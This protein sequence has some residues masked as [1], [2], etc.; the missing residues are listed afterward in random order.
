MRIVLRIAAAL[1]ALALVASTSVTTAQQP[2]PS[3]LTAALLDSLRWRNIGP[4]GNRFSAVASIAGNTRIYYAGAAS[5][6]IY[7]TT[8]GGVHWSAIFDA[9]PVQSIGSLAIAESDPNIVWAGTGEGKIRSHISVGQGVYKSTDAGATWR[10]MGLEKTGRIPRTIIHPTNPDIVFVCALGHSYGDQPERGVYRTLDGGAT[11]TQVLF[12][13]QKTG[14]SDLAIDPSN[15]RTLFAGMWQFEIHTWGRRSGGPGSGLFVS[16]D[17]GA[18]WTRQIG[19]GLPASPVGKVAVAIARSNPQRVFA[20]IETGDGIPWEGQPTGTGQLWRSED[21]GRRWALINRDRNVM[22]RAHYYSRL[23]VSPGDED[24]AYFL[25]ASFAKSIDG[26]STLVPQSGG[27]APGGDHHDIWIDPN[28]PDRMIVAHDQGLSI[29][30]N[31]GR[32]WFRQRLTNAQIY[33]VTVDNA[34]PYNVLGNKQD[35]PSYR[36]PSNSRVPGGRSAGISRGMWHSVGGGESGWATPDPTDPTIVWST[37]SGSGNVGGIVVRFEENRRQFRNVEVWPHQ[38]NGPAEGVRYR[39]VWDAPLHISPHDH[40]TIYT[41]SQHVHRTQDGGQSWQVISPDLTRND[42]S[43]MGSSGGLTG[44]NIGVEYSGVVFGIAESPVEKGMIWVGTN[45]GQVQVTRD[46]GTTWTNLTKNLPLLPVWGSVRSIAPSRWDAATAWLTVDAHQENN[47]D[48]WVYQTTDYGKT[49]RLIV[50]GL[51][52]N[53]LSYAKVIHE[54]PVR[55][56]LLYLGTENAI[57][58]SFNAGE[59]WLPL[60]MNLP[61]APVSGIVVQ[62]HFNDL[63]ISTYGRGFWILDDITPLQQL[64]DSVL[65]KGAHLFAPRAAYR[66][67]PITPPSTTYDDPT[68]GTDPEYGAAI[69]YYL[70][71]PAKAPPTVAILDGAGQVIRTLTGPNAAGLNRV[72]WDLRGALSAEVRLFTSPMYAPHIVPGADGR[73]APGTGRISI[74]HPPGT[75]TVRLTVDSVTQTQQLLV[76]K[77]PNSAGTEAD[78]AAQIQ[79]V[80]GLR[81]E[82]NSAASAVSRIESARVQLEALQRLTAD[83]AVRRAAADMSRKLIDLEMNLVELR[84]TGAGQDGV[85]FGSK[86]ISK[87][88]YLANGMSNGDFKPTNQH[89]E[90]QQILSTELRTHLT[91]LNALMTGDL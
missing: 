48:P 7:K 5:G 11:W 79:V 4:E 45:D 26:G 91:A 49:W 47:R 61:H 51:P 69:N 59:S 17:G 13:D 42:R 15:P 35:E 56:G 16:R 23:A 71:A 40:N 20:A 67:R 32:T 22:G 9:Q 63:V 24:E 85:R 10:L 34:I 3:R 70:R 66:F 84:L 25:T 6:G 2:A 19:N 60:Q 89:L 38:S 54:D 87:I 52:K 58:V 21:G 44:D 64:T 36:G 53:M 14:C 57:Y 50:N 8:D 78:I 80:S 82:L 1:A 73:V 37:A 90:V 33:H 39:F 55:R 86:L 77:D 43:R 65:S 68:V 46:N 81:E 62:P 41:G 28:N 76:R 75:Y 29:S 31:R 83:S 74:L 18:T 88:G 30:E 12:V 72:H 27:R